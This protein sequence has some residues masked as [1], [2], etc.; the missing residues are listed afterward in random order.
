MF[1]GDGMPDARWK[2]GMFYFNPRDPSIIVEKRFGVGWTINFGN[3]WA[4]GGALVVACVIPVLLLL[5]F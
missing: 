2:L 1:D 5:L 4:V 3:I